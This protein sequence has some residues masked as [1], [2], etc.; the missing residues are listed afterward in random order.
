MDKRERLIEL[1]RKGWKNYEA[2]MDINEHLADYLLENDVESVVRCGKCKYYNGF[3]R[4]KHLFGL[5]GLVIRK[6]DYCSYGK[7]RDTE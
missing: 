1:L 2:M 3:G 4:C 7:R 6:N 5:S